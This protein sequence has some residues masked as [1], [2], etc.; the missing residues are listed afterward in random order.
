MRIKT[1]DRFRLPWW[2]NSPRA[3]VIGNTMKGA[4]TQWRLLGLEGVIRGRVLLVKHARMAKATPVK[5]RLP[6]FAAV[7]C[8][9]C[10]NGAM[11]LVNAAKAAK[12]G[13]R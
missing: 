12:G 3:V 8:P 2:V 11:R 13:A 9:C 7:P 10:R 5:G 4:V 6:G 1:G